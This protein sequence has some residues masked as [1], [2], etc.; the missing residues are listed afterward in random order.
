MNREEIQSARREKAI[1][2]YKLPDRCV[3]P[4]WTAM[5]LIQMRNYCTGDDHGYELSLKIIP[6]GVPWLVVAGGHQAL[7]STTNREEKTAIQP[8]A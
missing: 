2:Q 8:R 6:D 4:L 3:H 1:A 5:G 7:A